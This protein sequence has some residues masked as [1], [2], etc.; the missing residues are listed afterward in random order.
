[1]FTAK[2]NHKN[3]SGCFN[4]A[5]AEQT[6]RPDKPALKPCARHPEPG[7]ESVSA[8]YFRLLELQPCA[9]MK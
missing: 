9:P 2:L 4:T 8:E 1:M 5:E 3:K 6:H 7:R